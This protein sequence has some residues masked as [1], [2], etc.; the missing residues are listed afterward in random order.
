[1]KLGTAKDGR[2]FP[3]EI[4]ANYVQFGDQEF[5]FAFVRDSTERKQ[6]QNRIVQLAAIVESSRDAIFST[7]LDG[8]I[9]SWN[10]G[11]VKVFGY[12]ER[13]I[14]GKSVSKLIPP[15]RAAEMPHVLGWVR[16]GEHIVDFESL[17]QGKDG[18]QIDISLTISPVWDTEGNCIGTSTIARDISERKLAEV[19][20]RK[21]QAQILHTQKLE[22]LGVLAGGIAHDFNNLLTSVLGYASLAAAELSL[23]SPALPMLVEIEHAARRAADLTNQMLAYSGKG[24]FVVQPL[25]LDILVQEMMHLLNTVISK[26]AQVVLNMEPATMTGDATQIRQVI[27]NLITNASDSLQGEPGEI[28]LRVGIRNQESAELLSA[29]VPEELPAGAYAFIEV[30]DTGCG[31]NE[32]TLRRVFDPFFTTKFTG[33]GLGMAAVLGIVRGH[34]GTIRAASTIGKGTVFEVLFPCS[35]TAAESVNSSGFAKLPRMSGTILAI[36]DEPMVRSFIQ[37]ILENAG[38]RV[39]MAKDGVEGLELF[40]RHTQ[41][42]VAV[43]L[44]L[45]M[46]R[47]DG[48]EVL[49]ELRGLGIKIPVL[50]MS[51]Y[52][53]Q[54]YSMTCEESGAS[55]FIQKPFRPR[56]LLARICELLPSTASSESQQ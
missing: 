2:V 41:E 56:D 25:R 7:S 4:N 53:E 45:T 10:H 12:H 42:I 37:L 35:A 24:K 20:R 31:M 34:Q 55:G 19:E 26:K 9:T 39:L 30:T 18:K 48:L 51:G 22:S 21:L 8:T 38:F 6:R 50:L 28:R 54:E 11:A 49:S 36:E 33:R 16:H 3:V 14:L 17:A 15:D 43:L 29:F 23:E 5:N 40:T 27:M 46:P 47:M 44:D 13:E 32:E 1:M 52:S